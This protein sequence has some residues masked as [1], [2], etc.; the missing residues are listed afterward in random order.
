MFLQRG[1]GVAV[2]LEDR[3]GGFAQIV[4]LAQLVRHVREDC[5]YRRADRLLTIRDDATDRH[6]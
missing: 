3:L 6:G 5:L 4:K 1:F 2:G